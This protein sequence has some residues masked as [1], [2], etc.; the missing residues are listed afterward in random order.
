MNMKKIN[1]LLV[2][3]LFLGAATVFT[4]CKKDEDPVVGDPSIDFKGGSTY[5]FENVTVTTNDQITIGILAAM[6][7]DTKKELTN[8][9]ITLGSQTLVD[10]SFSANAFDADYTIS[11]ASVGVFTLTAM[12]KDADNR[13][14]EVSFDITIELGGTAVK[15]T[16]NIEMGS[17]NDPKG[18]FYSTG[19]EMVYKVAEAKQNQAAVDFIFFK[20]ATNANSIAAPDDTQVNTISDFQLNDW[21]TKNQT[22]FNTTAMTAAEFDAI[23]AFHVFPEFNTS[24]Q[25]TLANNLSNG[26]VIYFKT[27]AGKKGYIKVVD[28]FSRGD[29]AKFEVIVEE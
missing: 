6:H 12:I 10:S 13:T 5:T 4:G 21:T 16:T 11:F 2:L 17:F 25:K 9:K 3:A 27:Q 23:G 20:G 8:L 26:Q 14:D 18:S 22:R 24:T 29:L 19:T 28:I 1:V 15:K 7:P